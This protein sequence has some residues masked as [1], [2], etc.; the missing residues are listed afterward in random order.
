[1]SADFAGDTARLYARYR[2]D[3]PA[4]QAAELSRLLGLRADD[5]LVDLGCGTG[6]LAVPLRR[7]CATVVGLDP[8]PGMLTGL[9]ARAVPAV[10]AM[11]GADVDVPQLGALLAGHRGAGAVVIGNALHWMDE[12][13]ALQAAAA[14]LRPGGGVAVVT[15]GPPLW[16]GTAPWQAS[17]RAVLEENRGPVRNSCGSDETALQTRAD[18]LRDHDL[19]VTIGRWQAPHEVDTDWV[20]GHLGSALSDGALEL[21]KP[22]GLAARLQAALREY[23]GPLVETIDTTALIGRRG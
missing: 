10:L 7:H 19:D 15:Q 20:I 23:D 17:V 12:P 4:D 5:V 3:L 13:A 14:L 2:R 9:R 6:Q 1:M 21:D 8:E 22:D 11:L 18:I 16:L